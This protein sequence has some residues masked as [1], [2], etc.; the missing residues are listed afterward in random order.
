MS[1][2]RSE[3][4]NGNKGEVWINGV[5]IGTISKGKVVKKWNYEEIPAPSGDGTIRV[6]THY[7]I[8]VSMTYR[9]TGTE[10]EIEMFNHN[11]DVSVIMAN[12]N[13]SDTKR[14][15]LKLDGV[16]FDEETLMNFE[17]HKVEEVELTGQAETSDWLE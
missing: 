9:S 1:S 2:K 5:Q 15:R 3:F 4:F 14:N 10:R 8:E 17:K 12:S 11:E 7:T 16:T 6:P 13:I